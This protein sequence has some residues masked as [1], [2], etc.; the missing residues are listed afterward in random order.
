[1]SDL[2]THGGRLRRAASAFPEAPRPWIDLST[3][4][5]PRPYPAPRASRAARARLPDPADL[6]DLEATA[7]HAFGAPADRVVAMGGSDTAI[8]LVA[9]GLGVRSVGIVE[10]T[11]GGHRA[12][13]TD[14]GVQVAAISR[15]GLLEAGERF[16]VVIVVNPNNPDGAVS[17]A[18]TLVAA[19][20]TLAARDGWLIVDEAFAEAAPETSVAGSSAQGL[21]VLRSFGK[22]HGLAGLRLGFVVAPPELA[23]R[24]RRLRGEW[25]VSA[26]AIAAG[27]TAYADSVWPEQ[28]RLRLGRAVRRLDAL[29]MGAGF[30]IVGGTPLF[31]LAA[32]PDAPARFAYLAR[33]GILTR[34]FEDAPRWL[35]FGL[36]APR[37]WPRLRAALLEITPP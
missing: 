34:P 20:T 1:M 19:A 28:T 33:A 10:P 23:R 29:L 25:P 6:E 22:F 17:A 9:L 30:E 3:G 32:A 24:L 7:A 13:W 11:Y 35:R 5:N 27:L 12:A 31:R 4:V 14:A 8:R 21:I 15:E 37:H 26:D 16:E 36:P 2:A 18:G